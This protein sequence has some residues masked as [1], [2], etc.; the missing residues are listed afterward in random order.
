MF[1]EPLIPVSE[2]TTR[3]IRV[4]VRPVFLDGQSNPLEAR[5]LWAYDIQIENQ[6]PETVQLLNRKWEVINAKGQVQHI[7][8]VGVIGEQPVLSPGTRFR[9]QSGVPLATPSGLMQGDYEME[10]ERGERFWVKVP[11]FSLDSPYETQRSH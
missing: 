7:E 2:V 3:A 8:G 9:Y 11:P 4:Q 1:D 10:N 6:G 5:F